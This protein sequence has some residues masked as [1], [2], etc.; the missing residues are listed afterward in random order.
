MVKNCLEF[1][2]VLS[3]A[4]YCSTFFYVISFFFLPNFDIANF[5][6]DNT[7][8][9]ANNNIVDI[10]SNLKLQ[11]NILNKWFKDVYMKASPGKYHLLLSATE[12]TNK[13]NI[14][15]VCINSSKCE[16]LLGVNNDRNLTFETH[17]DSLCK[18][19]SQKFN[20]PIRVTWSLNFN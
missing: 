6:D 20:A 14:E 10:L 5:A 7:P 8:Y 9:S 17:V 18:K 13:L 3:L 12:E 1:H 15:D 19:A 16:K 2:K 11:S 4:L